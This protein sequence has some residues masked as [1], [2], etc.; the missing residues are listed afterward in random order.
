MSKY[1]DIFERHYFSNHYIEAQKV[2]ESFRLF[3]KAKNAILY[4]NLN[5]LIMAI[6]DEVGGTI[7]ASPLFPIANCNCLLE[8][9]GRPSIIKKDNNFTFRD[10]KDFS[11]RLWSEKISK[12]ISFLYV[13]EKPSALIINIA[14]SANIT[15]ISVLVTNSQDLARK[16]QCARSSYGR[17][18]LT[19]VNIKSN[20]RISEMHS[21]EINNILNKYL[22]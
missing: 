9:T 19:E 3:F 4:G 22:N 20:G 12:H 5:M 16:L 15:N 8:A 2:E 6:V 21:L 13:D 11:P 14:L 1:T 17:E 7:Y 10:F 18:G